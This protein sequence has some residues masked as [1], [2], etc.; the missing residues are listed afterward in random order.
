[1][2]ASE[3]RFGLPAHRRQV[4]PVGERLLLANP[5]SVRVAQSLPQNGR[6]YRECYPNIGARAL[7]IA[8]RG[9]GGRVRIDGA[10]EHGCR[11][12]NVLQQSV[13]WYSTHACS[14]PATGE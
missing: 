6:S 5:R 1:M 14:R 2:K 11:G 8:E 13:E 7:T 4:A 9:A 12:A 3:D 10:A